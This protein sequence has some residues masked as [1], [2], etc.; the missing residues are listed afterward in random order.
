VIENILTTATF[1][2]SAHNRQP[3]R[4]AAGPGTVEVRMAGSGDVERFPKRLDC[5]I[6]MLHLELGARAAGKSGTWSWLEA[7][8]VARFEINV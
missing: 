4:F 7:P 1:A 5:G 6:A 3:W 8:G 2:P